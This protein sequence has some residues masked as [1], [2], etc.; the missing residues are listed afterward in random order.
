MQFFIE[1]PAT[2]TSLLRRKPLFGV[3]VND[4]S[5]QVRPRFNGI[6][7]ICPYYRV[8][9]NMVERCYS[10]KYHKIRPTYSDCSIA[11][12]WLVFSVFKEWMV[13]QDWKGKQLDKDILI[14]GNKVYGPEACVFVSAK[15]NNLLSSSEA[16]RGDFPIG[17]NFSKWKNKYEARCSTNGRGGYIG[18]YDTPSEAERAYIIFKSSLIIATANEHESES[19]PAIKR[20][21]LNHA[22]K[23]SEKL[24]DQ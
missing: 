9:S 21:L 23:L 12:E 19:N 11:D 10:A 13:L 22:L 8:W 16:T 17:V 7:I 18:S 4:A 2:K 14:V 6:K 15:I 1:K 3:G 20:G 24:K 5:Y